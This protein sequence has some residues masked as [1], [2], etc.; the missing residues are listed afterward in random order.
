MKSDG[1]MEKQS[2]FKVENLC[3]SRQ[4]KTIFEKINIDVKAGSITAVIGPSGIGKTTLLKLMCGLLVPDSGSI[5]LDGVDIHKLPR[6]QLFEARKKVGMLFQSGALF[7]DLSVYE[8][9]AFPIRQHTDLN[10]QQIDQLVK[11][12]LS[13]VGLAN[14]SSL[15]PAELSGG[16][17]R[18]VALARAIALEPEVVMYDEPFVGQDPITKST[19]VKLIQ[20]VNRQFNVTSILV[21]H[22]V[23]EV[24]SIADNI[25]MLDEKNIVAQGTPQQLLNSQQPNIQRFL[26]TVPQT[27]WQ[28]T[29]HSQ[30][31]T[32]A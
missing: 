30:E 32:D 10:Q 31:S 28:S 21:S 22:D 15:M 16:M 3:F 8:N 12:K 27:P 4:E 20:Q 23:P 18:R 24:F 14:T 29:G 1:L 6:K 7:T 13:A 25:Y 9:V 5:I 2:K 19:L 26:Q 17:S 11:E